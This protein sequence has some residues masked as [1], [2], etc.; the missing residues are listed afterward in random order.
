MLEAIL[1][2]IALS[3]DAFVASIAYGANKIKIP[4]RSAITINLVCTALLGISLFFGSIVR[5]LIPGNLVVLAGIF[6]LLGLGIYQLF[7]GISKS[8]I[9]K[10]LNK[11]RTIRFKLYD[12]RFVLEIYVDT[13][14]ADFDRSSRLNTKE[15]FMLGVALSLDGLAAGFASALGSINY[16][17]VLLASL[18][19]HMAAV[20]LGVLIGDR[21]AQKAKFNISW[22]SGVILISLAL[23][24]LVRI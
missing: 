15:A 4:F 6:I 2:I 21:F 1:L 22:L 13:T 10:H 14:K 8:I 9:E 24:K 5:E 7:Q 20:W 19:F 17:Q 11:N 12:F 3:I 23:V 16:S 18:V